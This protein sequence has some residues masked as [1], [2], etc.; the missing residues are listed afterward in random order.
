MK[1]GVAELIADEEFKVEDTIKGIYYET[2]QGPYAEL[3]LV[4]LCVLGKQYG[5]IIYIYVFIYIYNIYI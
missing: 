3:T 1:I 2:T 5:N 4:D